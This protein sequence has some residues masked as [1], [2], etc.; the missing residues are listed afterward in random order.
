MRSAVYQTLAERPANET[1]VM[2]NALC[3]GASREREAWNQVV[4][5]AI[6]RN[7]PLIPIVLAA[8]I[9]ENARRVQQADR[10]GRKL[11]DSQVLKEAMATDRIQEPDVA[12]LLVLDVTRLEPD[13]AAAAIRQ[14]LTRLDASDLEPAGIGHRQFRNEHLTFLN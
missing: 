13:A 8:D 14:H 2:T 10:I 9:E 11:A 4:D 12:E 1:F 5:L 3:V 6:A 7:V